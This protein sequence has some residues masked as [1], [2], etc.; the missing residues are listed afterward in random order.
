MAQFDLT[1]INCQ[2]LDRHLT[3]PL[4]EFL[5]GKEIY[6]QQE[7]LEYIL[8]TVNKTNMIDYTMDTRKRLN[9]S[10]EMPEELVQRKAEVLATLKQL[11]N[12]VAPIM[13]ATDI[14]KNGESM[15][16]SKTFVNALQKDYNFK[17]EHLESAYKL[18]KYL[19]ECG[20]Y[21][22]S[23]S[24]LYFCLIVMSP[25]D[26]NYLNVLW[27]KLAAE[28]LTLN[29]NTALEDLTR[30]RDYIDSANFSTIQ[31]L[32]QRTWLIHWSV[33]VFFNHPKGRDLIIEMF[34]YKPLYLNAIQTM[35]PHIMR[36]LATAVVINRTRR[37][38]LKDLIKVIQ[39][40]SYTYR[41]PITEFLECL[42]VNFDF[43]GARL[44]LHECQTVI[45]ND[46]FIVACLNEFVEDARLM[47]FETF[48]RIH[49]CI[50]ISMLADK[51]NMKPNEAECWIV[52]LIRNARLNAKIDSK[53]GHVVMG[54]QPLSPYQQLVEKIDSLSMRSEHL[55]GLIERK[56][57]QKNQESI[58][59]WKYY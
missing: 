39:Q 37:N 26:K 25:N 33:L 3:F 5:C 56:S 20:N 59:S 36:Y 51:L 57:K 14:L 21:Q 18:A 45:F 30:L 4:L 24:Y 8:D 53:L 31:A 35:C 9:L 46:F 7:L 19:Y 55:A 43:E 41:D 54:T 1:R 15:K 49:Q 47:I 23:T 22:E 42:Y 10:Q 58:D 44:K 52:N 34:L 12:E 2:Y 16:D 48:C 50:T 27:G 40:E 28:I 11:Q 38:A 6:N 13:K 29:W 32:Q 17:V